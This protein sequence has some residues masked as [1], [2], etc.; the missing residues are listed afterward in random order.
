[1]EHIDGVHSC[2]PCL[3]KAKHQVNPEGQV[4]PDIGTLQGLAVDQC[5]QAGIL[6]PG[7]QFHVIYSYAALAHT[8]L[9][10]C[11]LKKKK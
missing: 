11:N 8:K 4:L 5:K 3:L 2:L 7:S 9:Q 10:T 6:G 1:M